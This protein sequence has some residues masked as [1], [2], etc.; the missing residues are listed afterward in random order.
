M[1]I[2]K[3]MFRHCIAFTAAVLLSG[4]AGI[5]TPPASFTIYD[6]ELPS[7]TR[8]V[9]HAFVPASIEVRAPSWLASSAMQYRLDFRHPTSRDVFAESRWA[10]HPSEMLQRQLVASLGSAGSTNGH[11]RL[12]LDL[13]EFIQR[14]EDMESSASE[15]VVRASLLAPREETVVAR[16]RFVIVT[17]TITADAGGGVIAHRQGTNR[18]AAALAA[19]LDALDDGAAPGLNVRERCRY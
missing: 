15:L 13:D 6:L 12:R 7:A 1:A 19:W 11:C 18:L 3:M 9:G 8:L 4:C 17:P 10:G 5:A 14:F 16:E 2:S